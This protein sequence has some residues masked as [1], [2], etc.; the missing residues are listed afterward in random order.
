MQRE[1]K[2]R[3]WNKLQKRFAI[4]TEDGHFGQAEDFA[5]GKFGR[6]IHGPNEEVNLMGEVIVFGEFL[7]GIPLDDFNSLSTLQYTGLKDKNDKEIYEGD[8]VRWIV[9]PLGMRYDYEWD[10]WEKKGR[11]MQDFI[12]R[13]KFTPPY[14]HPFRSNSFVPYDNESCEII[15]NIF[16]DPELTE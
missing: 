4:D 13:V 10:E 5:N 3:V 8:I 15:G 12:E 6:W 14:I 16:E 7:S 1:L 11:T 2:F 9:A